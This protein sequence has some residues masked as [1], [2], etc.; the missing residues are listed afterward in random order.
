MT[1]VTVQLLFDDSEHLR[2]ISA[3]FDS[4]LKKTNVTVPFYNCK[5]HDSASYV[6]Y[7]KSLPE[8]VCYVMLP[9]QT[10]SVAECVRFHFTIIFIPLTY[11]ISSHLLLK[12]VPIVFSVKLLQTL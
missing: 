8:R 6:M 11:L 1:L 7:R 4:F 3:S 9:C 12:H 10:Q 5:F 2:I